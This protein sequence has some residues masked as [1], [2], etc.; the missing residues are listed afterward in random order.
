MQASSLYKYSV[1]VSVVSN[2][3]DSRRFLVFGGRGF[4]PGP[5]QP[6]GKYFQHVLS[7]FDITCQ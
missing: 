4:D 6:V 5:L 3:K 1:E 2:D 7:T